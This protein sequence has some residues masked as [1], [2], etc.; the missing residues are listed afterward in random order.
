MSG[1]GQNS[2][3]RQVAIAP[4]LT[5]LNVSLNIDA[6]GIE[7]ICQYLAGRDAAGLRGLPFWV[8]P[9]STVSAADAQ[10]FY[11][12]PN[13]PKKILDNRII[14]QLAA[15]INGTNQYTVV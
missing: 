12:A 1:V 3:S 10:T 2:N 11:V 13:K 15:Y 9:P 14:G 8:P 7:R 5:T 4:N 6:D